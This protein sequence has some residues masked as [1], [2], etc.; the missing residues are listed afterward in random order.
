MKNARQPLT[1][2]LEI[3]TLL[4]AS[5]THPTSENTGHLQELLRKELDWDWLVETAVE[6]KVIPLCY[7]NLKTVAPE[8]VPPAI[9]SQI[10]N[11]AQIITRRNLFLTGELLTLLRILEKNRILVVPLKGAVLAADAY[12]D[13]GLRH[14][15][16]LDILIRKQDALKAREILILNGYRPNL[17]LSG[18]REMFWL[19]TKYEYAFTHLVKNIHLDM[20]WRFLPKYFALPEA[21]ELFWDRLGSVSIAGREVRIL[22]PEN[23]LLFLCGHGARHGWNG[24]SLICDLSALLQRHCAINWEEILRKAKRMRIKRMLLVGLL[25]AHNLLQMPLAP[26]IWREIKKDRGARKLVSRVSNSLFQKSKNSVGQYLFFLQVRERLRD[27]IQYCLRL[28]MTPSERD[29]AILPLPILICRF[30]FLFLPFRIMLKYVKN[31]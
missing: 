15:K 25:L 8:K 9:L 23:Q 26:E 16:D 18:A 13:L 24:L 19:Q 31:E 12:H 27:R 17:V 28:V 11:Y 10:R 21:T 4:C 30:H 14:F 7:Q 2:R 29:C 1:R 5:Q 3:E 22:S 20:H 6:H